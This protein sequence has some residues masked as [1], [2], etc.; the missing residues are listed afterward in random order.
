MEEWLK[1]KEA[2]AYLKVHRKTLYRYVKEGKLR[3]YQ[4]GGTGRPRYRK[5][6]LDALLVPRE[7]S[8][9]G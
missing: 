8:E 5:Q 1:L 7:K 2:A 9:D 4:L 6:D 3:Q